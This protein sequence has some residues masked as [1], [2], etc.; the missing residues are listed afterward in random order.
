M[1]ERRHSVIDDNT[2]AVDLAL[3]ILLAYLPRNTMVF[4]VLQLTPFTLAARF[5]RRGLPGEV[6]DRRCTLAGWGA[7]GL[8]FIEMLKHSQ[9][10]KAMQH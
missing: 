9:C 3:V 7:L 4:R 10:G 6:V 5:L 1:L 8:G 2:D